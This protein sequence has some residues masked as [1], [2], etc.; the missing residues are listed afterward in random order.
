MWDWLAK[1]ITPK[2]APTEYV[3]N[4][5]RFRALLKE[6][7]FTNVILWN[8]IYWYYNLSDWYDALSESRRNMPSFVAE[9]FDCDKF[10]IVTMARIIFNNRINTCGLAVGDS[11]FGY[12]MWNAVL[13][14]DGLYYFEPQTGEFWKV[15][16]QTANYQAHLL[17]FA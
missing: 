6:W 17:I 8:G 15:E 1:L 13:T 14:P 2:P 5:D 10:A 9:K 4:G 12:H 16:G 3:I 7:G 11:P